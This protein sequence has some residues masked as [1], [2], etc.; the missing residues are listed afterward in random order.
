VFYPSHVGKT[1]PLVGLLA[2]D[3]TKWRNWPCGRITIEFCIEGIP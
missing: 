1:V 3:T 2:T